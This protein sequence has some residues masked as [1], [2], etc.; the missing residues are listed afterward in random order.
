MDWLWQL[1]TL[2]IL[3][4][5]HRITSNAKRDSE[6]RTL[7]TWR[8][9]TCSMN[10]LFAPKRPK[11]TMIRLKRERR[12]W[13]KKRLLPSRRL[14]SIRTKGSSFSIRKTSLFPI[15]NT[16]YRI[17][18]SL[19]WFRLPAMDEW[20]PDQRG[21]RVLEKCLLEG[22]P[23]GKLKREVQKSK[24]LVIRICQIVI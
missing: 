1:W 23:R 14:K 10:A 11:S 18:V 4:S 12:M 6:R 13:L 21:Y 5:Y 15:W 20:R 9:R 22:S 8:T 16:S 19:W 7:M 3:W 17:T 2:G 24:K